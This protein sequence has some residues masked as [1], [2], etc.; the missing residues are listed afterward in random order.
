[1]RGLC[2]VGDTISSAVAKGSLGAPELST[3]IL[4]ALSFGVAYVLL[5]RSAHNNLS[6]P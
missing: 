3:I 1:V 4:A 2:E 6:D 5:R